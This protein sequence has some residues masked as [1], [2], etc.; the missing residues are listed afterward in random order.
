MI[1][2]LILNELFKMKCNKNGENK[3]KCSDVIKT[4]RATHKE[5]SMRRFSW[6][7]LRFRF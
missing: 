7:G 6:S 2:V 1:K 3:A 4:E 5:S